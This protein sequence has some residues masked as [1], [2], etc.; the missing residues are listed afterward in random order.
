MGTGY[1]SKSHIRRGTL[2][3]FAEI[4]VKAKRF[5]REFFVKFYIRGNGIEI[6]ALHNPLKVP[7][8]AKVQY[9][10]RMPL[11]E[12]K[13]QYPD[14]RDEKFTPI[15]IIDD[16]ETLNK[17]QDSGLDFI[18]A[19]H[20]LEHCQNPINAIKNMLRVL[21]KGGILFLAI[22]NKQFTFDK[23]RPPIT[24]EHFMKDY[25][26][27][28]EWSKKGH[29]IN[30][31]KFVDKI[32]EP[33]EAERQIQKILRMDYSIHYHTWNF[34]EIKEFFSLLKSKLGFNFEI[35]IF[36]RNGGEIL[37]ICRKT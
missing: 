11:S 14:L 34:P 30:W 25:T 6:G 37:V 35:E 3:L 17:I 13:K 7:K 31:V 19:N 8:S 1:I 2:K 29:I 10:D 20:F 28:P 22:P 21:K 5:D 33:S 15:D 16:G 9:V 24:F 18:I 32:L 23:D 36:L 12:L 27:G 26:E 4:L